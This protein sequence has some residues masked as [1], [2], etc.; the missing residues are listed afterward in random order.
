MGLL[1]RYMIVI[2]IL[3]HINNIPW[4]S[5]VKELRVKMNSFEIVSEDIVLWTLSII[6]LKRYFHNIKIHLQI[7]M[8][9]RTKL[10]SRLF[11]AFKNIWDLF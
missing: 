3:I 9:Y 6:D 1:E 2:F 10:N 7:I 8:I 5:K 4:V 11:W